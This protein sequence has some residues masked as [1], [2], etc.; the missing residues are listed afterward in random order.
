MS[1]LKGKHVKADLYIRMMTLDEVPTGS[2]KETT[3]YLY[4]L[5]KKQV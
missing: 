2:D 4:D 5:Y 1:L 3:D